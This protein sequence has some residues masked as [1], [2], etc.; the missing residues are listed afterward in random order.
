MRNVTINPG[1]RDIIKDAEELFGKNRVQGGI[2]RDP[3]KIINLSDIEAKE[4][5]EYFESLNKR[6]TVEDIP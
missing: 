4:A 5:V 1:S 6:I 2:Y 3:V